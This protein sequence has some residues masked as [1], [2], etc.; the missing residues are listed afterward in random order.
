MCKPKSRY[1][2]S[3]MAEAIAECVHS[4]ANRTILHAILINGWTYERAAEAVD[5]TPRQV[6]YVVAKE[7]PRLE[8]WIC[9]KTS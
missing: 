6:G 2:N 9:Q 7:I 3:V 5:R 4:E 1:D 8:E